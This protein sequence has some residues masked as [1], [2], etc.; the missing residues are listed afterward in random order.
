M[1]KYFL[2]L[3]SLLFI[4]PSLFSQSVVLIPAG[5]AWKYYNTSSAPTGSWK[6]IAYND[7]SW[8]TG[9]TE[10]GYGDGGEATVLSYGSN[11]SNKY[12]SYYFRKS[13]TISNSS[14]YL[15]LTAQLVRDDGAVVYINGTEVKRSNIST[16]TVSYSKLATTAIAGADESAWNSFTIPVSNLVNGNNVIA[17]E[18][19]QNSKS[20]PDVSFNFSLSA[21]ITAGCSVPSGLNVTGI[22]SSAANLN[23]TAVAGATSYVVQYKRQ[24]D[25]TWTSTTSTT[26]NK[27]ITLLSASTVYEYNVQAICSSGNSAFS[28]TVTFTTAPIV[29][30]PPVDTLIQAG[31][32]WKYLDSGT[33]QGSAWY[34]T[35]YNDSAWAGGPAQ[36]GY[37]DGDEATVVGYG[38]NS[39]NR[40]VT[41]YFRKTFNV[42]DPTL[43]NNLKLQLVRD[44]G[45]VIY[46]N[47]AEVYRINMPTGTIGYTTLASAAISGTDES[48]WYSVDINNVLQPGLN[49]FA[50]EMHQ[51][52]VTSTDISFNLRLIANTQTPA[53][54]TL[55]RGPYLNMVGSNRIT[56][57][58]RTDIVTNSRVQYG[59]GLSYGLTTDDA[60]LT[61]EHEVTLTGLSPNTIYNYSIGSFAQQLQGDGA[62]KF[63]TAPVTGSSTPFRVWA[64]GDFGNGSTAQTNVRNAFQNYAGNNPVNLWLWLGDNAYETG[65]DAE[66]QSKVFN[67]YTQQFK[68]IPL[69]PSIGNHDYGNAGYQSTQALTTNAP[70]YSIF[71]MPAAG[72]MGGVASGTEKYYS[73]NYGNVHFVVI[74]SYGALNTVGSPMYIW[75]QNDLAANTQTWTVCYFHHPPYTH[76]THNSDTDVQMASIRQNLV[77]LFETYH[78]DLVLSGHSHFNERS[79]FIRG[80]YGT[81]STFNSSMKLS[82]SNNHFLKNNSNLDGCVYVICGTGGQS[83]APSSFSVMPCMAYSNG[84]TNNSLV[85]DVSGDSLNCRFLS[86]TGAIVDEFSIIKQNSILRNS[87]NSYVS[88]QVNPNPV[89]EFTIIEAAIPRN[90]FEKEDEIVMELQVTDL[91][92]NEVMVRKVDVIYAGEGYAR[93]AAP[94]NELPAGIYIYRLST[95]N[96]E[97]PFQTFGKFFVE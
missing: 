50:V 57:R 80:H 28:S 89:N 92:G 4:S 20:S 41:T 24:T 12:I 70:Y 48:A 74:D 16:G 84:T 27:I 90:A 26:A 95:V 5:S 1:K 39:S 35:I 77:P 31:A 42:T 88:S 81:A 82:S 22:T 83:T 6:T 17:I 67:I 10:A 56:I 53:S 37:G 47:G 71:T 55:L 73:Y 59:S 9:N 87:M 66:Y 72:E 69:Y 93:I 51:S 46:I 79:Y 75:L 63:I 30:A 18:V 61:K 21:T 38:P 78:V 97:F 19:H 2:I 36:L 54:A 60:V 62:N 40:Y 34:T 85:I 11:S 29:I 3:I 45:A 86:T 58:W 25:T 65:T 68:N 15:T 43:Y 7:A 13:F 52:A 76:G 96:N 94:L 8:A 91:S 33:N 64:L 49:T 23:W 44:D 32:T 14:Q